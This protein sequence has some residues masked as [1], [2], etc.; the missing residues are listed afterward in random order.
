M[1]GIAG[2]ILAT[3]LFAYY[4]RPHAS[5]HL[6]GIPFFLASALDAVALILAIRALAARQNPVSAT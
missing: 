4:T 6:P 1:T 5:L 3:G 2:P